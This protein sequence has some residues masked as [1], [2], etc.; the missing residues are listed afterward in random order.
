MNATFIVLIALVETTFVG[1]M[2]LLYPRFARRGLLFGVY[3]GEAT[4]SSDQARDVTRGYYQAMIA[5]LLFCLVAQIAVGLAVRR[6]G[7]R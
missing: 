4:W 6:V 5:W 3:V 7:D 2:F 1:G